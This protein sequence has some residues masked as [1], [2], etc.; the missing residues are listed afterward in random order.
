[1]MTAFVGNLG[2]GKTYSMTVLASY[3]H[4]KYGLKLFANY[5]LEGATL[6][7]DF[8]D[9]LNAQSGVVCLDEA[10]IFLDSRGFKDP[11]SQKATHWLLQTR[12][13]DLIVLYTTQNFG[14]VDIRMR[15][16]TDYL[17][18]CKKRNGWGITVQF[19]DAQEWKLLRKQSILEPLSRFYHLYDTKEIVTPITFGQR[20]SWKK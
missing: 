12:K 16:I 3:L 17:A 7:R 4:K 6:L 10:H 20:H 8:D 11:N 13:K 5:K 14:Q 19:V 2:Q 15:R 1:M 18:L 9:V